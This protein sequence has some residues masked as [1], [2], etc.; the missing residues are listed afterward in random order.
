MMCCRFAFVIEQLQWWVL[1]GSR[2]WNVF[3][4]NASNFSI[5]H[6][7]FSWHAWLRTM[8]KMSQELP[9]TVQL[10]MH[11][12][13]A[14]PREPPPPSRKPRGNWPL[15]FARGWRIWPRGGLRGAGHI[16][17][18]QSALWSPHVRG[19]AVWPFCLSPGGDLG[20]IWPHP[21]QIPTISR[22]RGEYRGACNSSVHNCY[23]YTLVLPRL[24]QLHSL[25]RLFQKRKR[26][27]CEWQLSRPMR[28]GVMSF[29][30]DNL[31]S[32]S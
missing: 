7:N 9:G 12:S 21:G 13:I 15:R 18:R 29:F 11:L 27:R 25:L 26:L 5:Y 14:C 6:S 10:L 24:V 28:K 30:K 8:F 4:G 3:E 23:N 31:F 16:D 32:Y 20:Y 22:G 2:V 19:G 17:R 1:P